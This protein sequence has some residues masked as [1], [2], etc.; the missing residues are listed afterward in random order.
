L[1]FKKVDLH[2]PSA[3][4]TPSLLSTPTTAVEETL[5]FPEMMVVSDLFT[6][7]HLA[8]IPS[9]LIY[10]NMTPQVLLSRLARNLTPQPFRKKRMI[11]PKAKTTLTLSTAR[12]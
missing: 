7:L 1:S 9:T 6:V 11:F 8:K 4:S 10:D 3:T 12:K 2:R 5:T